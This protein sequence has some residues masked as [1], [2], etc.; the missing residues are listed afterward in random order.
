[1]IVDIEMIKRINVKLSDDEE[2][3]L[4]I[5]TNI[6]DKIVQAMK[7]NECKEVLCRTEWD[8]NY[9]T[10]DEIEHISNTLLNLSDIAELC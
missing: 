2:S 4:V 8:N 1:M 6:L 7:E 9:V 3:T 10:I 5:A